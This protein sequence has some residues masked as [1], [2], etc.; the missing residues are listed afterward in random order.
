M[1][2]QGKINAPLFALSHVGRGSWDHLQDENHRVNWPVAIFKKF[3][4]CARL[5]QAD[6]LPYP[7]A[8]LVKLHQFDASLREILHFLFQ[9][10]ASVSFSGP[11][12]IT[13]A[14]R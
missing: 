4:L 12:G 5:H 1:K 13:G 10:R 14:G 8:R 9:C 7:F 11:A 3:D 2:L 6:A